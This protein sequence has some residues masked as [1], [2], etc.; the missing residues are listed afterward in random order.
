MTKTR[1]HHHKKIKKENCSPTTRKKRF[2]CYS[3]DSLHMMKK[4]WNVRHP[5][6]KIQSNDSR[7]IWEQLKNYLG[8]ICN[9]ESCW[10]RQK[11]MKGKLNTELKS[12]TFAPKSPASWKKDPNTWLTSV[13]IEKVMKQYEK[14]Y[15]NFEFIGPSPIDFDTH[16][17]FGD[18]VWDE[19][20]RFQLSETIKRGKKK[21][22]V[23]FNLDPHYKE[24][25]HWVSLFIDVDREF[26]FYFDSTSD[27]LPRQIKKF[28]KR[29]KKQGSKMN[30]HFKNIYENDVEHQK[31]DSECGIYSLFFII[32]LLKNK[33]P[34]D[35]LKERISDEKMERLRKV[36][37]N[38]S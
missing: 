36:Y 24:G 17:L 15:R 37:F 21:I 25:S 10:M 19:L 35:F 26:I 1:K 12:Y 4:Y 18:C 23:I 27:P 34:G 2:T 20:C 22:G 6:A 30:I 13:D 28:I 16:K 7:V 11:F 38:Q 5:D 9:R 3:D 14:K 29:V 32:S 8:D 33:D 31:E